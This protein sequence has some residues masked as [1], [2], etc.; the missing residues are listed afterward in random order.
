MFPARWSTICFQS[1]MRER[2][3][4]LVFAG[5]KDIE[6]IGQSV[7]GFELFAEQV[8]EFKIAKF[9]V[10]EVQTRRFCNVGFVSVHQ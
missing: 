4:K 8:I 3:S 7:Q 10:N 6:R 2:K 5:K 1:S 9:G